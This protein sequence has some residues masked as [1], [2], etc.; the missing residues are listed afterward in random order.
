MDT[1]IADEV[2]KAKRKRAI[3]IAGIVVILIA[4]SVWMVRSS[5][6]TS[7]DATEITTAVVEMGSIENTLTA[8]GEVLPEFEQVITSPINASIDNV[9]LDAGTPV[10]AG[11]FILALNKQ[12]SQGEYARMQF[13]LESKRNSIQKIRLEL[14]KSF[15]DIQSNNDIKALRINSLK[16]SVEDAKRLYKAGGGTREQIEQAELALKVALLEKKQLENDILNKQ[17][18]MKVDIR[19]SE[20]AAAIQ[21]NDLNELS[22][23]LQQANI[24]ASRD[25]VIT[26][27]NKNIG[28]TIAEGESLVRIA[29][30][31]SFKITGS[32]S[33]TYLDQVKVGMPVTIRVNDSTL[34]GSI[35]NINP[36][37]KNGIVYFDIALTERNSQLLRPNMKV[38][39]Y[40]VTA[41]EHNIMR[42]AN[43]PAFKGG[44][45]QDVFVIRNGKAERVTVDI[46]L[47]S[48]DYVQL[49]NKVKP[50]DVIITSDMSGYKNAKEIIIKNN[51]QNEAKTSATNIS[52]ANLLLARLGT[53]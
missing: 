47:T 39:V 52:T 12:S 28:S 16:A 33:D 50:G 1:L 38:D 14:N 8:S 35:S 11:Q 41:S 43:G 23:K 19:E 10:K 17:Q 31:G 9:V 32:I 7:L 34:R 49:K 27:V 44:A 4:A 25:G 18:T 20:I 51:K 21:Q 15:F 26:W 22:R 48:F 5:I 45:T 24:T 13:Q 30:L 2:I 53:I 40:L 46:G 42:V 36:S 37:V 6:K 3:L 29:D